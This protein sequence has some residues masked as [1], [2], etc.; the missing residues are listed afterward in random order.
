[1]GLAQAPLARATHADPLRGG[2]G[3]GNRTPGVLV[4]L[5]APPIRRMQERFRTRPTR[6]AWPAS[7]RYLSSVVWWTNRARCALWRSRWAFTPRGHPCH[8]RD[9]GPPEMRDFLDPAMVL[10]APRS[11]GHG[12]AVPLLLLDQDAEPV[13]LRSRVRHGNRP[14]GLSAV[15]HSYRRR[16]AGRPPPSVRAAPGVLAPAASF[17][18]RQIGQ[19]T[20]APGGTDARGLPHTAQETSTSSVAGSGSSPANQSSG[21]GRGRNVVP[22]PRCTWGA[23]STIR[24]G[25]AGRTRVRIIPA[26]DTTAASLLPPRRRDGG[27]LPGHGAGGQPPGGYADSMACGLCGVERADGSP[28]ANRWIIQGQG[29]AMGGASRGRRGAPPARGRAATTEWHGRTGAGVRLLGERSLRISVGGGRPRP[30]RPLMLPLALCPNGSGSGRPRRNGRPP[31]TE[32]RCRH[33]P[34]RARGL[35]VGGGTW[36]IHPSRARNR[37]R[38]EGR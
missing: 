38:A 36:I 3:W 24:S 16:F 2:S 28:M 5:T 27:G 12:C 7:S 33:G 30:S 14:S 25:G 29:T 35:R 19:Y 6:A 11:A 32:T 34:K 10:P 1:M 15:P 4:L 9:S 22:P 20:L 23:V 8:R 17:H 26:S 37:E 31:P 18:L 13:R 21:R